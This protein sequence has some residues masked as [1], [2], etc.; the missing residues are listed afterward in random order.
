MDSAIDHS[1]LKS[2]FSRRVSCPSTLDLIVDSPNP[3]EPVHL[4]FDGDDLFRHSAGAA[5]SRSAI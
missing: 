2:E 5:V 3:Q 1:L 4:Y